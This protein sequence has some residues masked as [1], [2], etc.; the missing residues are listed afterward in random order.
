MYKLLLPGLIFISSTRVFWLLHMCPQAP[1]SRELEV[2]TL[3]FSGRTL[4]EAASCL[5]NSQSPL[6]YKQNLRDGKVP[7]LKLGFPAVLVC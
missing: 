3:L 2:L 1:G 6:L 5:F 7:S 4:T